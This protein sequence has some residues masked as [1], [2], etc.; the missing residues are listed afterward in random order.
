MPT[1]S[2]IGNDNRP[3]PRNS[4]VGGDIEAGGRPRSFSFHQLVRFLMVF[5]SVVASLALI[6]LSAAVTVHAWRPELV[7][8]PLLAPLV[9]L[10]ALA[11]GVAVLFGVVHVWLL[12]P[13]HMW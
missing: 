12:Y 13:Q 7:P 9:Y 11:S 10:L 4:A 1:D 6:V 5:F 8:V 3:F 2:T